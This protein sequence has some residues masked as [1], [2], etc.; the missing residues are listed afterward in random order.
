MGKIWLLVLLVA[1][2]L[3]SGCTYGP[4]Q[5]PQPTAPGDTAQQTL[6][7]SAVSVE[8]KSFAFVP[9]TV[10]VPRGTTVT[11][12]QLDDAPHTVTSV[13]GNILDSPRL[14][15]GGTYSHT[16]NEAGTFE[17]RCTIHPSMP[18]GKVIVT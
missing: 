6:T 1:T 8:I 18:H 16:F 7:T 12:T 3:I 9:D 10:T 11:W 2:L 5:A 4:K 15:K 13:N 14:N 17:Y